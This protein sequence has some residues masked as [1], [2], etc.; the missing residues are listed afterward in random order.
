[1]GST[2]STAAIAK[3]FN[4]TTMILFLNDTLPFWGVVFFFS[5]FAVSFLY[6]S[7]RATDSIR[8][9]DIAVATVN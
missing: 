9:G 3:R 7:F 2:A 1:M 4:T 6:L 8:R 5:I